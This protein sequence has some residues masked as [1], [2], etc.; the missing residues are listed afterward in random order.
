MSRLKQLMDAVN[1]QFEA[2]QTKI[3]TYCDM[4]VE[5]TKLFKH[6]GKALVFAF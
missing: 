2:N 5:W 6:L 3:S 4:N 1:T